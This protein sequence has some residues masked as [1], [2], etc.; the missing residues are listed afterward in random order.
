[1][2]AMLNSL[3]ILL[4]I[5]GVFYAALCLLL[6]LQQDRVLFYPGP[7]DS[8]LLA[9]WKSQSVDIRTRDSRLEGWWADNP[10]STTPFVILYFGGNA[11]DVLYTASMAARLDA[12]RM[13]VV[14]YRGYGQ[15]Q[16]QPSQTALYEDGLA[17]YDYV[18]NEVGAKPEHI[19]VMG[20]SLGSGVASMLAAK[21]SVRAA[22]LITP[23]DSISAV[24]ASH[25]PIFPV[26]FL[27]RH[28]FDSASFAR[29]TNAPAL[30]IAAAEDRVIPAKHAQALADVWAG[31]QHLHVLPGVGHNDLELHPDY[32]RLINEF[33]GRLE[34]DRG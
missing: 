18:V 26:K 19:V 5:A 32:F 8:A 11:E 34:R 7:N 13:L 27:L 14:N 28:P 22:I 20:R 25:Y 31:E 10:A 33:L 3:L 12:R 30:I 21:R 23:F 29:Q 17:I 4:G 2:R 16:G 1:M 6:Y 9:H 15:T 24:A